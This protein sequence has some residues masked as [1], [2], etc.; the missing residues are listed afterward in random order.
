MYSVEKIMEQMGGE[1][2]KT[3]EQ[4]LEWCKSKDITCIGCD[5]QYNV[6][7]E[8]YSRNRNKKPLYFVEKDNHFYL[9]DKSKGVSIAN[10]RSNSL[11]K[12]KG[13]EEKKI[14]YE[15]VVSSNVD[16]DEKNKH[17]ILDS[18][19]DLRKQLYKYIQE[20]H[21]V[22]QVQFG[23]LN[24][25]TVYVK[26]FRFGNN[27]KVTAD[28]HYKLTCEINK[29]LDSKAHGLRGIVDALMTDLPKSF[30]NKVVLDIFM[31]WKQRQHYAHLMSPKEWKRVKGVEQTWDANKQ[32]TSA[33]VNMPCGWLIF[34][35]FA[36][37]EPYSGGVKDAYYY[38]E[39]SNTMP[40][41]G[42]GWYSRIILEW[43]I[44]N[45]EQF[46]VKY[47]IIGSTLPSDTFKPFVKK[48]MELTDKFKYITNT[49]CGSLNTHSVKVVKGHLSADKNQIVG[50]CM[51]TDAHL[52]QLSDE[53]FACA[54]IENQIMNDN[55]MPMYSQILD[56]AAIQLADA[57]KHLEKKG[58]V[59]RGYNT[60]SITFKSTEKLEIDLSK[61]ALGGWKTEEPK[62]FEYALEP[63]CNKKTYSFEVPAWESE[64]TED[65]F[66]G[67]E[68]IVDYII[69]KNESLSLDG[70]AGFGKSYLLDMLIEKVGA[71][72]CL[73]LGYTNISANNIGG[74]TFH[75]TFKIDVTS[76]LEKFKVN[77]VLSGKK[78]LIIDEKSQV[79]SQLYRICQTANDMGIPII[80]AGDFAQ[81][82]PV[83]ESGGH[84]SFIRLICKN[85]IT[86][87][88]YKRGDAELL[89]DLMEVRERNGTGEFDRCEKGR[90]HFCFTKAKRDMINNREMA[91]VKNG[92]MTMTKNSNLSKIY[93]GMPLR[94][95]ETKENGDWLNNERWVLTHMYNDYVTIK[96][97]RHAIN[98]SI[99]ILT[100]NFV[101]GY[102]M[103]I[104]SSQG[105]T[106]KEPYTIWLEKY[107]AFSD[108]DKWRLYYTAL[109]RA[110]TKSQIGVMMC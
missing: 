73:V 47:E 9:M 4:V 96:N 83:G 3:C 28:P 91:K 38:I 16:F 33:L 81:I 26:S 68:E 37:P 52:V 84:E 100:E 78:W 48:A 21:S 54:S 17:Y 6:I 110:T 46:E 102:A 82:L 105:L 60:D 10:S 109:S 25:N 59:I 95:C 79:P 101:P 76:G 50:R 29:N 92:Y 43:L 45:D 88:K 19:S 63:V 39:T 98:V 44:E 75:N 94:S 57:I 53:V 90:L 69:N 12:P 23:A 34:N 49:L 58:C 87:T 32:Y 42:N 18:A 64:K 103:T 7:V 70:Q 31:S 40:C 55:N 97:E 99:K 61:E 67:T 77:S 85:L 74:K 22:P 72:N 27:C 1:G 5:D 66:N 8:Y 15:V 108:D 35:M 2:G 11:N 41:K 62:P 65:D 104:H 13:S 36:L 80:M 107:T 56:F 30:M 24:S 51:T 89:N 20:K 93:V 86:L 71:E 14:E 106:I